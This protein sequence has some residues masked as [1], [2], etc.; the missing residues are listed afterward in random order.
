MV[1][2]QQG[3]AQVVI[4]VG[5]FDGGLVEDHA[6]FH[7]VAL[8]EGTGGDVADDDLQ[9]HDA[10]L[11]HQGFPL[12]QLLNEVGG[13]AA[14][15]QLRHQAVAHLVVDDT[16]AYDGALLQAVEG[17]GVVLVVHDQQFGIVGS[18]DLLGL[19][20]VQLLFLFHG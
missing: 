16:L 19:A 3:I 14:A 11:L 1:G 20:F 13:N 4:L 2:V 5:E 12:G 17:S 18:E 10:D 6:F 8:G 7:A 15:L 9:R